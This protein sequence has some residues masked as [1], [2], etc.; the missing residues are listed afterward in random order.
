MNKA[1]LLKLA[2][3]LEA[4][5]KNPYGVRFNLRDWGKAEDKTP[6]VDCGTTACAIGL[7]C[8][9]PE[10][11]AE[12]LSFDTYFDEDESNWGMRPKYGPRDSWGAVEDFFELSHRESYRLF[13]RSAYEVFKGAE[14]ELAVAA[15]I[16]EMVAK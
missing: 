7:A 9:S 8:L 2:D 15:R 5:A 16:R 10:F 1:R 3:L 6:T 14:A 12:G 4:D 11:Q 13:R